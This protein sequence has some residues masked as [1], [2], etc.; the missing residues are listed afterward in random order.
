MEITDL[1]EA[2]P[3]QMEKTRHEPGQLCYSIPIDVLDR[4]TTIRHLVRFSQK[5]KFTLPPI[6]FYRMYQPEQKAFEG[7]ERNRKVVEV[8]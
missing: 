6:R 8:F 2:K 4:P 1:G 7:N 5:G 3:H